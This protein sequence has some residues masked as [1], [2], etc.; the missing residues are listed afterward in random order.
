MSHLSLENS[1]LISGADFSDYTEIDRIVGD[2]DI[3]SVVLYPGPGS[4]NLSD[5]SPV[6]RAALFPRDKQL[7]IFVIDGT[8]AT[9]RTMIRSRN[10]RAL[11]RV[12]FTPSYPSRFYVRRQPAAGCFSTVE[13]IHET[14][15]LL[16]EARGFKIED[17]RHDSL[18]D[19]FDLMVERQIVWAKK[20]YV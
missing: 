18:L 8:W 1:R 9:A 12:C 7:A 14:I 3:H 19:L 13:A 11:P 6:D 4:V 10:L 2:P 5:V 20:N 15:E 16:G 17:R